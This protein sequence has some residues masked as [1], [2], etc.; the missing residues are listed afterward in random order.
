M[1]IMI[2]LF[3]LNIVGL[4]TLSERFVTNFIHCRVY[5]GVTILG[6][7]SVNDSNNKYVEIKIQ[8]S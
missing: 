4:G 7:I 6:D 1:L 2:L 3:N 8:T 5:E